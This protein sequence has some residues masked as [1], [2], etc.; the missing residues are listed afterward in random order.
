MDPL[1]DVLDLSRASG[2]LMA[3]VRACAPWGL[4]LPQRSGA[5][6]HAITSGMAW[7]RVDDSE[8]LQLMPGDVFLLP[9]GA[10]HRLSS[11]PDGDCVLFDSATKERLLTPER[12][13]A[14]GASGATTTFVCAAFDYDLEVG[15]PLMGLLPPVIHVPADPVAGRDVAPIVELLAMEVG[16]RRPGSRA[17]AARLLDTLLIAAI[18]H[19]IDGQ[20]HD[21]APSWL[22]ALRDPTLARALA[23]LHE[24]PAEPWTVVSLAREVHVSRATLAR[25][26]AEVVGEPPLTYLARWRMHL[27][28]QRLKYSTETVGAIAREVGYTSEYAFN[29][30]FARHRGQPP[31]RYRRLARAA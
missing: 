1:S 4:E 7:L 26:F 22:R 27:A 13:L 8:P 18:R 29:R 3:S 5:A 17:A 19:W 15:E 14:L 9:A 6:F 20:A 31:G 21:E 12:D 28:A 24:R 23:A 2:A 25:R 10:R 30:A 11:D 16:T